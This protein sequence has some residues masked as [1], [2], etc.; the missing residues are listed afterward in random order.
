[1]GRGSSGSQRNRFGQDVVETD[2]GAD[3]VLDGFGGIASRLVDA[4]NDMHGY[5][6]A[7][8]VAA[9]AIHQQQNRIGVGVALP[10][11]PVPVPLEAVASELGR[12]VRQADVDVPAI[13]MR[14]KNAM[15]NHHSSRLFIKHQIHIRRLLIEQSLPPGSR[16]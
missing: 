1:M 16:R 10:A 4:S 5:V 7:R 15:W 9:P 12:V 2:R 8:G 13:T 6:L 3:C 11:D 14:I